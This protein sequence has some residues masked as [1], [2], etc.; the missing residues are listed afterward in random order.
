MFLKLNYLLNLDTMNLIISYF[1]II[2]NQL[3]LFNYL[4]VPQLSFIYQSDY[5]TII[6]LLI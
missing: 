3:L 4:P 6:Y 2:I 1:K 5:Q